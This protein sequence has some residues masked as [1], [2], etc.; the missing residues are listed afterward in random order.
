[1]TS[2]YVRKTGNDTT[3]DG[4]TGNPWLTINKALV[5]VPIAGGHDIYV[6][7]GTYA[8]SSTDGLHIYLHRNFTTWVTVQAEDTINI[9][10][11]IDAGSTDQVIRVVQASYVK[12]KNINISASSNKGNGT[13]FFTNNNA[14]HITFESCTI[15]VYRGT[16]AE[17]GVYGTFSSANNNNLSFINC[18]FQKIGGSSGAIGAFYLVRTNLAA[19]LDTI[20]LQ[21]CTAL[22]G[23]TYYC[24]QLYGVTNVLI[25]GCNFQSSAQKALAIGED[26]NVGLN[27]TGEVRNSVFYS[28]TNHAL[29]VGAGANGVWV[30][31]CNSSTGGDYAIVIKESTNCIIE[32]CVFRG[33]SS[34]A[35]YF[36]A[37]NGNIARYNNISNTT[38]TQA[39]QAYSNNI[40]GNKVYNCQF[41][42]NRVTCGGTTMLHSWRSAG[43]GTG[44]VCDYNQYRPSKN[45]FGEIRD[46]YAI[47]TLTGLRTAWDGYDVSGND[48]HSRM[49]HPSAVIRRGLKRRTI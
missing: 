6:G 11:L 29:L 4:S 15:D 19:T 45:I 13:V 36:K 8:E 47:T 30:H 33:G 2:Y 25:D 39:V 20:T 1:M 17:Y 37:G 26:S 34:A 42:Y 49:L 5:T 23:F 10:T 31:N 40:G 12:F 27:T 38:G 43:L 28:G 35:L 3:G 16:F 32:K 22:P 41:V 46:T 21:G 7:A 14:H 24:V 48:A 18:I 9:P 44:N